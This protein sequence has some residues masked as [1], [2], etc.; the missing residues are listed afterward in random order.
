MSKDRAVQRPLKKVEFEVRFATR[1][2]EKGWIDAR[3]TAR[4]ALVDAWDYLTRSPLE[5]CDRC[6][7]LRDDLSTV[8]IGGKRSND[9]STR[10]LTV[11][12][13]GMRS[14]TTHRAAGPCT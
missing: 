5:R 12:A 1:E 9:G 4:N 2:A 7:P 11:A 3:A 13:F 14:S 10:S 6:Y 8:T